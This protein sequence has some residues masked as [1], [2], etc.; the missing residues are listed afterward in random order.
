MVVNMS[1]VFCFLLFESVALAH[2]ASLRSNITI[3]YFIRGIA[4]GLFLIFAG[5]NLLIT[6]VN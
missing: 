1:Y 5:T 6:A 3:I 2:T 4:N